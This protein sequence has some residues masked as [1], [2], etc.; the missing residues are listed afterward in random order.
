MYRSILLFMGLFRFSVTM[1]GALVVY[2]RPANDPFD[3]SALRHFLNDHF[4]TRASNSR[5][6]APAAEAQVAA[7]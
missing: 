4:K 6:M 7:E 2:L 5:P 1:F 3:F